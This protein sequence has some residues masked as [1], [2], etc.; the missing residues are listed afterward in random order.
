MKRYNIMFRNGDGV[1]IEGD[2]IQNDDGYLKIWGRK[3]SGGTKVVAV[4]SWDAICG[5][6]IE[7]EKPLR[8]TIESLRRPIPC[9]AERYKEE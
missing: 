8:E 4:F 5:F 7:E 2:E 9:G 6:I 3:P 1:T